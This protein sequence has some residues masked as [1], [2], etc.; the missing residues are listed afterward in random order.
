GAERNVSVTGKMFDVAD[1]EEKVFHISSGSQSTADKSLIDVVFN[2]I[3]QTVQIQKPFIEARLFVNGVNSREYASNIKIPIRGEIKWTNNLDTKVNDLVIQAKISGNVFDP[4]T[5]NAQQG[6]YDSAINT[7]TWDKNSQNEFNEI[8]PGDSGSV[9]FSVSPLVLFSAQGG[10]LSNPT[11]NIDVSISGKQLVSGYTTASL[12]NSDRGVIKIISDVGFINKALYYS[13]PFT[14]NGPVPPKVGKETS[15]TVV[16]S[17]SNTANAISKGVVH[18]SIPSWMRF[19][20]SISPSD[21]DLVYNPSTK[22]ITW[23]VGSISKGTGITLPNRSVSF[24]VAFTPSLSQV[25]AMPVIINDAVLTGHDDFANVDIK[26]NKASLR[27]FLDS[28]PSFP[29][30]GGTVVE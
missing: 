13:G 25:G 17:L 1:G 2:S 10:M 30:T 27:T 7:I 21:E 11:I 6:F 29:V 5:I 8:S 23:N 24:Q 28:D 20:G 19:T 4:K 9:S 18:S 3:S 12:N 15:Y 14:N 22:E 16:W 26:V